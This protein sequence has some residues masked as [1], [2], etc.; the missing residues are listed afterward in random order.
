MQ[1]ADDRIGGALRQEHAVPGP[2]VEID[3]SLLMRRRERRQAW[4]PD[5]G[6]Q[7]DRLDQPTRDLRDCRCDSRTHVVDTAA[8]EV[9]DGGCIA[10]I[11]HV[12]DLGA[13]RGVEQNA[14]EMRSRAGAAR[15]VLQLCRVGLHRGDE[16][17]EI[18]D[19][20]IIARDQY[21]WLLGDQGNRREVGGGIVER[22]LVERLVERVGGS[23]CRART[24]S[25]PAQLSRRAQRP[26]CRR[27]RRCSR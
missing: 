20:K 17:P 15:A 25:R 22:R 27:R 6:Q 21:R 8:D 5:F 7:R 26:S 18:A 14:G 24:D 13:K 12:D 4:R 3:Q 11:G 16:F 23:H 19:G 2:G 9:L 1:L 10:S